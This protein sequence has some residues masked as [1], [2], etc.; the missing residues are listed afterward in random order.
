MPA[1]EHTKLP[2]WYDALIE[3]F[4]SWFEVKHDE[5]HRRMDQLHKD[6]DKYHATRER[7]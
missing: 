1:Q 5:R 7:K 4:L 6:L 3:E 2:D